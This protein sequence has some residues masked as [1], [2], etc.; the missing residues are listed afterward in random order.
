MHDSGFGKLANGIQTL[1]LIRLYLIFSNLLS[2]PNMER[3]NYW[4]INA[5][6][7]ASLFLSALVGENIEEAFNGEEH[8]LTYL[9]LID[10]LYHLFQRGYLVAYY[11]QDT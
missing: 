3:G 4:I 11:S 1:N 9:E 2:S 7:E 10:T 5:A 6:L 8:G